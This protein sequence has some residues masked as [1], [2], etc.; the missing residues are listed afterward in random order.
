MNNYTN[1]IGKTVTVAIDRPLGTYHPRDDSIYYPVNYGYIE[2]VPGGDGSAQDAYLLGVDEPVEIYTGRVIAVIHRY[3][4]V[5]D[6]WIVA[7]NGLT[8]TQDEIR[9][10]THFVEQF[11]TIEI[12]C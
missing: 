8:F 1:V 12:F 4:D 7:P 5:E 6:K 10:L 2:G 3:D 9:K 11:F